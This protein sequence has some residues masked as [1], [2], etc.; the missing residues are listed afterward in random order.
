M[1]CKCGTRI[2]KNADNRHR[3]QLRCARCCRLERAKKLCEVGKC[4]NKYA[5]VHLRWNIRACKECSDNILTT[6]SRS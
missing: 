5:Y 2:S 4:E 3:T 1:I 6:S